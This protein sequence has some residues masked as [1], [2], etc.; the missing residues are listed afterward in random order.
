MYNL[1]QE[2]EMF[3]ILSIFLILFCHQLYAQFQFENLGK[4][5]VREILEDLGSLTQHSTVSG[6][7]MPGPNEHR[8]EVGLSG[9]Y[10]QTPSINEFV[11]SSGGDDSYHYLPSAGFLARF[12]AGG[13]LGVELVVLPEID[14]GEYNVG[15]NSVALDVLLYRYN[16]NFLSLKLFTGQAQV[17]YEQLVDESK[18]DVEITDKVSGQ[19]LIYS[20]KIHTVELYIGYG[21]SNL[22][23]EMK[24]KGSKTIF[25]IGV[26]SD[27]S[28]DASSSFEHFMF[29]G[30]WSLD[31][32]QL[33]LEYS[34]VFGNER[35]SAKATFLNVF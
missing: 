34:K 19:S 29:G 27:S 22:S 24:T 30:N 28:V 12:A 14:V 26:S 2:G 31:H 35:F 25:D 23:G 3:N 18:V 33:G 10:A 16:S 6:A 4:K 5:D 17:K 13:Y 11:A 15:S 32:Y 21:L 20:K 7:S 9:S 8:L 1:L